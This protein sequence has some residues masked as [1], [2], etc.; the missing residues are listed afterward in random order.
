MKNIHEGVKKFYLPANQ[1]PVI[2]KE[3]LK[4]SEKDLLRFSVDDALPSA[5]LQFGT[6][7]TISTWPCS[8]KE[9]KTQGS[10]KIHI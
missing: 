4:I 6:C 5:L 8:M 10:Y 1:N 2:F 9:G 3:K 7:W